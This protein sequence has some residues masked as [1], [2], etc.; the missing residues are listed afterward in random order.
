MNWRAA[1]KPFVLGG[2]CAWW[3][4]REAVGAGEPHAPVSMVVENAD[5]AIKW[6]GTFIVEHANR[7]RPG[8]ADVSVEPARLSR[9]VVQF[10]SQYQWVD[11][12]RFMP[13][14]NRHVVSFMHGKPEDG[15]D[16][17]E[18]IRRFLDTTPR[19]DRIV[20]SASLVLER[21]AQWGVARAKL[22]NIPI[23]CET[24]RFV[25]PTPEQRR[26]MRMRFGIADHQVCIGS[27]QKDGVG[28]GDGEEPKPIKGPDLF[29][30]AIDRL[31]REIPVFV[32]LTGPARGFVKRGL[33]RLGV[34]FAHTYVQTREELARC[35]HALDLYL[36]TS[37]EE[38]G[39]MALMESM[40][41]HVP[42]VSTRVGMSVDLIRDGATGALVD[43]TDMA[44]LSA[45]A[46]ELLALP[47]KGAAL[48]AAAREA[49][50]VADWAV[51]GR[52]HLQEVWMPLLEAQGRP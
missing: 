46:L 29:L 9:R 24:D 10:G 49:V 47:D 50:K 31:R 25:P 34:P 28:W 14:S 16:V 5:W 6:Y 33:E 18:H 32:L 38:G 4:L 1:L 30:E 35:Y 8:V 37:R 7:L 13:R 19:L 23:G 21:L 3:R 52:R 22:V 20:C 51:V 26:E 39:P 12:Q 15:P 2:S 45:R 41:S 43:G 17:A 27:F 40:A 42:V 44:Q 11:W 36:I 48:R